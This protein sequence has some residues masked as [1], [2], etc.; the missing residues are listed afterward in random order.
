MTRLG[1]IAHHLRHGVRLLMRHRATS[2]LAVVSFAFGIALTTTMFSLVH[3]L[4]LRDL[5]FDGGGRYMYVA[6]VDSQRQVPLFRVSL[7]DYYDFRAVQTS[8]ESLVAFVYRTVNLSDDVGFPERRSGCFATYELFADPAFEPYLGRGFTAA[9]DRLEAAPVA[10]IG[11]DLWQQ[12]FAGDPEVLGRELRVDG[13][14][15]EIVGVMPR[16]FRFPLREELWMPL[17]LDP[18]RYERGHSPPVRLF[19]RLRPEVSR[20]AATAELSAVAER[21]AAEH[22]AT[23][24]G[25]AVTVTPFTRHFM[26]PTLRRA[27]WAL[28]TLVG[29][30]LVIGCAN[31]A[32]LLLA[33]AVDRL[34][35]LATISA[36][37][38]SRLQV[39]GY[40]MSESLALAFCGALGGLVLARLGVDAVAAQMAWI[41]LPFWME[42]TLDW[43]VV[44][45][46][47]AAGIAAALAAGLYPAWRASRFDITALLHETRSTSSLKLGRFVRSIVVGEVGVA[48]LLLVSTG[49]FLRTTLHLNDVDLG[50]DPERVYTARLALPAADYPEPADRAAFVERLVARM[51][52]QPDAAAAAAATSLPTS[53]F[54]VLAYYALEG[55]AYPTPADYPRVHRVAVT[56]EFFDLFALPVLRGRAL[57]PRD[58]K[59][60]VAVV[61]RSFAERAWPGEDAVGRRLRFGRGDSDEPWRTVV[62]VVGDLWPGTLDQTDQSGV[63]VPHAQAGD[64]SVLLVVEARDSVEPLARVL[65]RE[66]QALDK[67]VPLFDTQ[68]LRGVLDEEMFQS[69][70]FARWISI[71]GLVAMLFAAV[72]IYGANAFAVRQRTS[73]IGLR[74]AVGAERREIIRLLAKQGL[75]RI[76]LGLA[77]GLALAALSMPLLSWVL[78]EVDPWDPATFLA[79]ALFVTAVALTACLAPAAHAARISPIDALR[80]E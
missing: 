3:G 17:R 5:P 77:I 72:G 35:E 12:R 64:P 34:R 40:V 9:D 73:E 10:V 45:F 54:D 44:S 28:L 55:R 43:R 1:L 51:T 65:R 32:S 19:G 18:G 26:S 38:A 2:L 13:E 39:I 59:D 31:V 36:L 66:T 62:G 29:L 75:A 46:A 23:H 70:L 74:M 53:G 50:V 42:I 27:L 49:L 7:H 21:L 6:S 48:F 41:P 4:L 25:R 20:A 33:R 56:P 61:N 60:P 58:R 78:F 15:T 8:F 71:L 67:G 79:T 16:G 63:Y 52:A 14:K 80:Y 37:G 24:E 57:T 68:T 47:V 11:Y 76:A 30:G 69:R 22:P